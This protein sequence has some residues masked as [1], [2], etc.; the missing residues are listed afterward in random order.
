MESDF[1]DL[2]WAALSMT[3]THGVR[4]YKY[5]SA[6]VRGDACAL[7]RRLTAAAVDV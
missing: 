6:Y 5:N 2:M 4:L 1:G 3:R 7:L